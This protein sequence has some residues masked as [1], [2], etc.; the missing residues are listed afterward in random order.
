MGGLPQFL[1]EGAGDLSDRDIR[2]KIIA[3]KI[4]AKYRMLIWK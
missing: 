2:K 3:D 4:Q 1:L